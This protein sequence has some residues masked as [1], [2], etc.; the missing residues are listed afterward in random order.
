MVF[1][2]EFRGKRR[3]GM[4]LNVAV[5]KLKSNESSI[6]KKY[7]LFWTTFF[8]RSLKLVDLHLFWPR[9]Q[10]RYE[11]R[12]TMSTYLCIHC[13]QSLTLEHYFVGSLIER[14]IDGEATT[15][16]F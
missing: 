9:L 3:T 15:G 2:Q 10:Y 8:Y 13:S 16:I 7:A 14:Y 6:G 11:G 4:H 5:L 12:F 1:M